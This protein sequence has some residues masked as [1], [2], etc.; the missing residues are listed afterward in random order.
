MD[1]TRELTFGEKAVGLTFNHAEGEIAD[2]VNSIKAAAAAFIDICHN[3]RTNTESGEIKL[4]MSV[5]ITDAQSAQMFAVKGV[6][7]ND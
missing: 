6:T 5:A 3:L 4:L 1:E 7:W 2:H